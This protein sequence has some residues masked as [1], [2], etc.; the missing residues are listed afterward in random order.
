MGLLSAASDTIPSKTWLMLPS[1]LGSFCCMQ[2]PNL[3][4][5]FASTKRWQTAFSWV[6][7]WKEVATGCAC[8]VPRKYFSG[9]R[10]HIYGYVLP[11]ATEKLRLQ[12][13]DLTRVER[14]CLGCFPSS[15]NGFEMYAWSYKL[16]KPC[17]AVSHLHLAA[18]SNETFSWPQTGWNNKSPLVPRPGK[19]T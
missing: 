18:N 15:L 8:A 14:V 4:W 3:K 13:G 6:P 9:S 19:W 10:K 5:Y 1:V 17:I 16:F 2:N 11:S 7:C 12:K